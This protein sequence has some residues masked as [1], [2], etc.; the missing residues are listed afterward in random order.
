MNTHE[1]RAEKYAELFGVSGI[2]EGKY[3]D[4][5][6]SCIEKSLL[7]KPEK[8]NLKK[9]DLYQ[10]LTEIRH[11]LSEEKIKVEGIELGKAIEKIGEILEEIAKEYKYIDDEK[12]AFLIWRKLLEGLI[13]KAD[14]NLKKFLPLLPADT[15]VPDHSIW[16]HLKISTSINAWSLKEKDRE[17]KRQKNSLFLFTISPVQSF[18][19]QA[20]KAQ[21]FF[22]G[23]FLLS[24]LTF[25]AMEKVIERIWTNINYLS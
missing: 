6:A 3:S 14:D 2:E 8:Y 10:K 9:E 21:D 1:E 19:S 12:K 25:I 7:P 20:R 16:E 15:R 4:Q 24:Y 13:E 23:S 5:I 18:I 11:P 17:F 22:M